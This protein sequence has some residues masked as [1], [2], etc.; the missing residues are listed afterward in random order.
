MMMAV[1]V[2]FTLDKTTV[3][4]G[5]VVTGTYV[6]SG[7]TGTPAVPDTVI[8]GSGAADVGSDH[9]TTTFS[10]TKAGKP[11]VPPLA[12]SFSAPVSSGVTWAS[13]SDPKVWKGTVA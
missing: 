8:N 6:V 1:S 12:A 5:D 2:V 4:P 10:L 11:A 13:T 9:Y 7:N 3:N